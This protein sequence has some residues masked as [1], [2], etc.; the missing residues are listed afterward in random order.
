MIIGEPSGV[1]HVA[2]GYYGLLKIKVTVRKG[3][4]HR[5]TGR[6]NLYRARL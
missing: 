6:E 4:E 5:R 3:M 1:M 2:I